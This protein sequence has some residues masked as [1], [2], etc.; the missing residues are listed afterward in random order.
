M[1]IRNII[2]FILGNIL[3]F[4]FNKIDRFESKVFVEFIQEVNHLLEL[5]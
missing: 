3:N 2:C 1:L 4:T 5:K